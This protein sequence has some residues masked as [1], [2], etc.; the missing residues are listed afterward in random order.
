MGPDEYATRDELGVVVKMLLAK[1]QQQAECINALMA[2][3]VSQGVI[4]KEA[5]LALLAVLKA[6][7]NHERVQRSLQAL[8]DFEASHNILKRYEEPGE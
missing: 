2:L 5:P 8:R 7:A 3:L 4:P 6:S 1:I